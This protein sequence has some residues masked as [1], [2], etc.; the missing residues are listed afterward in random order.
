MKP[1]DRAKHPFDAPMAANIDAKLAA[2]E[3]LF[4]RVAARIRA[5]LASWG[6]TIKDRNG[7][8]QLTTLH[9]GYLTSKVAPDCYRGY[10]IPALVVQ[11]V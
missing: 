7:Q 1:E 9:Y 3:P 8:T 4:S 11:S 10:T 2:D 5:I 6:V